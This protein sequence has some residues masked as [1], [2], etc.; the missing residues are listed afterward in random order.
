MGGKVYFYFIFTFHIYPV[1]L[2]EYRNTWGGGVHIGRLDG[3]MSQFITIK[4][5]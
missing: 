5:T 2:G 3:E 4:N 1:P